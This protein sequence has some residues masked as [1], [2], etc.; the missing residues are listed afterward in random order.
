MGF[1]HDTLHSLGSSPETETCLKLTVTLSPFYHWKYKTFLLT[2]Q[3]ESNSGLR[4]HFGNHCLDKCNVCSHWNILRCWDLCWR[5]RS[6]LSSK[7]KSV[8]CCWLVCSVSY[9]VFFQ[10]KSLLSSSAFGVTGSSGYKNTWRVATATFKNVSVTLQV[11]QRRE[12]LRFSFIQK[13]KA[14]CDLNDTSY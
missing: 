4:D 13:A 3:S 10:M 11:N 2:P 14:G 5:M 6:M 12:N 1:S 9:A 7:S 8:R